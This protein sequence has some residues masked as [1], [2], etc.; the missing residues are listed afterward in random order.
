[1]DDPALANLLAAVAESLARRTA[2]N[3]EDLAPTAVAALMALAG[4]DN[5][6]VGDI[7]RR[8][9]LTHSAAVRLVDRLEKQWFVR[10][11]RRVSREVRVEV[12]ARGRRRALGMQQARL[13]AAGSLVGLVDPQARSVLAGQLA[14]MMAALRADDA[15]ADTAC[16]MCRPE[17]CACGLGPPA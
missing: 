9:G 7:A 5:L 3:D 1:M 15:T 12:T 4:V 11:L 17:G 6:T 8:V 14:A 13:A 2:A 10:R 16:R